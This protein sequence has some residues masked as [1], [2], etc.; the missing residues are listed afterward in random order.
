MNVKTFKCTICNKEYRKKIQKNQKEPQTCSK[1]CMNVLKKR[2]WENTK[3]KLKELE[4]ITNKMPTLK[5]ELTLYKS[6]VDEHL[7]TIENI[8]ATNNELNINIRWL[9][10]EN[11]QLKKEANKKNFIQ[12]IIAKIK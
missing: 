7:K 2:Q 10:N 1:K 4:E 12:K 5:A 8:T 3:T 11:E 9:K 6:I